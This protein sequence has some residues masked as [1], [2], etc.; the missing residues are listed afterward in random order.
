MEDPSKMMEIQMSDK[1]DY[2]EYR[3][4]DQERIKELK[5]Y[6]ENDIKEARKSK[7]KKIIFR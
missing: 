4:E 2:K 6:Y 1:N 3:I 5:K 7:A